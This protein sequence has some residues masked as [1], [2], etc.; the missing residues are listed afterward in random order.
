MYIPIVLSF[1]V[2]FHRDSITC[3]EKGTILVVPSNNE[4]FFLFQSKKLGPEIRRRPMGVR[5]TLH[6]DEPNTKRELFLHF[7]TYTSKVE[8]FFSICTPADFSEYL[9]TVFL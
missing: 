2:F 7:F 9:L 8:R 3:A 5:K 1:H 6:K 4:F